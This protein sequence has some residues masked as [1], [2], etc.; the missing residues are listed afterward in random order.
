MTG[1]LKDG[2]AAQ[3]SLLSR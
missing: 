2:T 1:L 3:I